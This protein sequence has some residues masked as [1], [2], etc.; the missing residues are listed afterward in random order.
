[1]AREK[2]VEKTVTA[3]GV[4]FNFL[5]TDTELA[6]DISTLPEDIITKLAIHGLS[7]KLGDSYAGADAKDCEACVQGVLKNLQ[8]GQ[9]KAAREGGGGTTRISLLAAA[10]ARVQGLEVADCVEKI[11]GLDD[12]QKK[13]LRA[14]GKVKA[15]MAAIQA[16]K[17]AAA[18]EKAASEGTDAA[19]AE[20]LGSLLG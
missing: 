18:A 13:G 3:T 17:A 9:W 16:E 8:D 14:N 10:V 19:E 6:I 1:M 11:A 5:G 20:E 15:A 4:E 2:K 7:Q 12:E